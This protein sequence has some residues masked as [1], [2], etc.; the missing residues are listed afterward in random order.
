M[1]PSMSEGGRVLRFPSPGDHEPWVTKEQVAR[2]FG[3]SLKTVERW[4]SEGMPCLRA[5]S[6][7]VRYR[8]RACEEWHGVVA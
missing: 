5:S 8:I 2:H 3:V 1:R 6:R 7:T 4:T